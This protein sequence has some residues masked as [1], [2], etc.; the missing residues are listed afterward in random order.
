MRPIGFSTGAVARG[1]FATAL[2]R[3]RSE[4]IKVVELSALRL[5]ELMPL[6]QALPDLD[7]S[8]FEFVSFHAPSRFSP[9]EESFVIGQLRRLANLSIPIVVHPDVI[10]NRDAWQWIGSLLFIENMDKRSFVGQTVR[11]LER[12]FRQFPDAKLCC[13][14]GHARQVD[15][16]MTEAHLILETFKNR[17][18]E[19][20]ISDVNSSSRHDPLS[21]YSMN[22]FGLVSDL[23]PK[24]IPIVLETLIDEGQSTIPAEIERARRALEPTRVLVHR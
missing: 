16:T 23:I 18:A 19:I 14:I 20:H 12:L 17:L 21:V 7:L 24:A 10:F 5:Q 8:G 3:L 22:A 9:A 2:T 15:P 4:G 11:D 13:D 1:D 6:V